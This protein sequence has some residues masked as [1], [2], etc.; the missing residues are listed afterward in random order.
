ME[1]RPAISFEHDR[2]V[3]VLGVPGGLRAVI[4]RDFVV[5]EANAGD[6][7]EFG[8]PAPVPPSIRSVSSIWVTCVPS[9]RWRCVR[10]RWFESLPVSVGQKPRSRNPS[11][12]LVRKRVS[13]W[14]SR[15]TGR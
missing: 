11:I 15:M 4:E 5:A 2:R 7:A 1:V 8:V 9:D 12:M 14:N 13:F 6:V 3:R 10:T